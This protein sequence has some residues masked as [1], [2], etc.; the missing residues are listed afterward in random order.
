MIIWQSE[1]DVI[2]ASGSSFQALSHLK[3]L[4]E[5]YKKMTP[6]DHLFVLIPFDS[7]LKTLIYEPKNIHLFQFPTHFFDYKTIHR[8]CSFEKKRWIHHVNEYLEHIKQ[9]KLEKVVLCQQEYLK[10]NETINPI[11][12]LSQLPY[13]K[14]CTGFLYQ[15]NE[16]KTLVGMSPERLFVLNKNELSCDIIAGTR[17]T[18]HEFSE[19]EYAEQGFVRDFMVEKLQGIASSI[20]ISKH[21]FLTLSYGIHLKQVLTARLNTINLSSIISLLHPTPAV[22]GYPQEKALN[23]IQNVEKSRGYFTGLIGYLRKD[24]VIFNV[25]IRSAL[26]EE[27]QATLCAGV[28]IVQGSDPEKEWE[29]IHHK[30]YPFHSIFK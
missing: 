30:F 10:F 11:F 27:N 28:G 2:Q 18:S 16:K 13:T 20:K 24:Q 3:E 14:E 12:V 29:E 1:E 4:D 22:C 21:S 6:K 15:L 7:S 9:K 25:I 17:K 19:K 8:I 5:Q 23:L 26:I